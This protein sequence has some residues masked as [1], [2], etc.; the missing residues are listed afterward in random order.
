MCLAF[1]TLATRI[2]SYLNCLCDNYLAQAVNYDA[3]LLDYH[4]TYAH[5]HISDFPLTF[6]LPVLAS[7][8]LLL[9]DL[10]MLQLLF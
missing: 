2:A 8:S 5:Y 7:F 10:L 9:L 4:Q 1:S 3:T 6:R